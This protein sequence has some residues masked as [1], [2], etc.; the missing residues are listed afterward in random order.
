MSLHFLFVCLLL[1]VANSEDSNQYCALVVAFKHFVYVVLPATKS[2]S[3][4]ELRSVVKTKAKFAMI[5]R[6][7]GFGKN[8]ACTSKA[9]A[10]RRFGNAGFFANESVAAT[11]EGT[12]RQVEGKGP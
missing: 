6:F 7:V 5:G 10:C 11:Y 4:Q 9:E 12:V 1:F 8:Y 2:C 3:R